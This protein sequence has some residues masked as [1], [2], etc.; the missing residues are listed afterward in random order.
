M[1]TAIAQT[2]HINNEASLLRLETTS[3]EKRF[4]QYKKFLLIATNIFD[5]LYLSF[6]IASR[7]RKTCLLNEFSNIRRSRAYDTNRD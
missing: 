7:L 6:S 2:Q 3:T 1:N 5:H 4:Y